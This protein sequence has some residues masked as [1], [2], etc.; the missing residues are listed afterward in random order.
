MSNDK[1]FWQ[2]TLIA[3]QPRIR[4][5]RSFDQRSHSYLGYTLHV[6][7][8]IGDKTGEFLVGIGVAAQAKHQF[9]AGDVVSGRSEP[10]ANEK[11][12]PVEY[13][14]TAGLQ[15]IQRGEISA[16]G[17]PPPWRGI[18]PE[19]EIYQERGHRRLSAQT[20]AGK[21]RGCIWGCLMAVEIIVDHWNPQQKRYRSETFC[22]GPKSCPLYKPGP[23]RK[24][25]G[26]K[27]MVWEEED[28]VDED[29]TGHRDWD[30]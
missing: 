4:L 3:V 24:V 14:K 8:Q 5:T 28:W 29:A 30:E 22:Y 11:L 17:P 10:V 25:P 9:H 21:C 2:G 20:Y 1:L 26:R 13:Y 27:G 16:S 19:L 7:G 15:I 6:A 12:E 18:P 23:T